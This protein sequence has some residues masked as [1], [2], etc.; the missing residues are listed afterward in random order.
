ML[1]SA[2]LQ[3]QI[4]QRAVARGNPTATFAPHLATLASDMATLQ[5]LIDQQQGLWRMS[6]LALRDSDVGQLLDQLLEQ[7]GDRLSRAGVVVARNAMT[8]LPR[9]R[10]DEALLAHALAN[11]VEVSIDVGGR[12]ELRTAATPEG[13]S[14]VLGLARIPSADS[15]V[16]VARH[17]VTSHGGTFDVTPANGT[18]RLGLR[19]DPCAMPPPRDP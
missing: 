6:E 19:R 8:A 3:L 13:V 16:A 7:R 4:L 5:G 14:I 11:L 18:I 2:A 1:N 15:R 9:V 12:L 17:I 10:V